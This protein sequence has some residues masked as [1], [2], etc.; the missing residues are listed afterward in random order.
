[1]KNMKKAVA[2]LGAALL[3]ATPVMAATDAAAVGVG[4]AQQAHMQQGG[5]GGM[6]GPGMM[7]PGYGPGP[8]YGYGPGPGYGYGPGYGPGFDPCPGF[9][10]APGM[11][12]PGYGMGPGM[13]TPSF[14]AAAPAK[15]LSADDVRA[16]MERSLAWHDNKRLK[17]G[18]VKEVDEDTIVADILTLD[19]SLVQRW[20]VDRHTGAMRPAE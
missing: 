16:G 2:G 14:G 17:V 9:G 13:M 20:Q 19:D 18:E 6:M 10:M 3:L 15:D 7:G 11:M 12:G 4:A 8:G 5:Q 1:M